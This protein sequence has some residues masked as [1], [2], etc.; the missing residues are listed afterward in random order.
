MRILNI[1]I[2]S[3]SFS[4]FTHAQQAFS[5]TGGDASG[6]GGAVSYTVGQVVYTTKT[7]STGTLNEGVQQT[8]TIEPVDGINEQLLAMEIT[9]FPNPSNAL[10]NLQIEDVKSTSLSFTLTD[11][12][13][14][15]LL[16]KVIISNI[17]PINLEQYASGTYFI[18]V[19]DGE[20]RS[21]S[22]KVIKQ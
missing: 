20:S 4:S 16:E 8:Y 6:S 2:I 1:I 7:D 19:V 17:T 10:I 21:R 3:L 11:I 15:R 9:L 12:T 13:G 14:K 22:F 18:K 5:A